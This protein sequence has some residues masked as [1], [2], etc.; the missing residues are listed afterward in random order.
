MNFSINSHQS[1]VLQGKK[2][3][4]L[5][6][7]LHVF[8]QQQKIALKRSKKLVFRKSLNE[9]SD[10]EKWCTSENENFYLFLIKS[11]MSGLKCRY[12]REK[13]KAKSLIFRKGPSEKS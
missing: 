12:F 2:S 11:L 6:I 9:N 7:F 1:E 10:F 5:G 3:K 13:Q 8:L 4:I